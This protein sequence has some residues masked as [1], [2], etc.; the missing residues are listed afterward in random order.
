[1][2]EIAMALVDAATIVVAT[3][4]I[5]SSAHPAVL[6]AANIAAL[7]KPKAKF[8]AIMTTQGWGGRAAAQIQGALA[9]L[10]VE[11]LGTVAITGY[12]KPDDEKKIEELAGQI[13]QKH[14]QLFNPK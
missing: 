2:G 14:G 11:L 3:P 7:L 8:A 4:T 13:A 6:N 5:L 10:P 1:L 9:G 12:P